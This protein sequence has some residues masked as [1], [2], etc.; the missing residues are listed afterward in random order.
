MKHHSRD[1]LVMS[2][3]VTLI[4]WSQVFGSPTLLELTSSVPDKTLVV[5]VQDHQAKPSQE[6]ESSEEPPQKSSDKDNILQSQNLTLKLAFMED[7]RL[8]PYDI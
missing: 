4:A 7:P 1:L 5:Q 6:L 8:F 2:L 3:T